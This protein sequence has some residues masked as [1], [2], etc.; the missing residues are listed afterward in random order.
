MVITETSV[1]IQ[2]SCA[3]DAANS[4]QTASSGIIDIT[5]FGTANINIKLGSY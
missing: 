2:G 4:T 3:Q 5:Y 1:D